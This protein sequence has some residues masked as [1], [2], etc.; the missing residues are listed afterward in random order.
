MQLVAYGAQDIYI[1]G[2]NPNPTFY[3]TTAYRH[4]NFALNINNDTENNNIEPT[5]IPIQKPK[6]VSIYQQLDSEGGNNQC[7]ISLEPIEENGEYWQC[8]TCNKV[9][10]WEAAEIWISQ[11]KTCP[12]CRQSAGLDAM[13]VNGYEPPTEF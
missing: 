3:R 11:H 9:V 8:N 7:V 6:I 10:T 1:T 4:Q 13:Y 5:P 2:N 12:Y